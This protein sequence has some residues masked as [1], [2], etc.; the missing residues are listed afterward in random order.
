MSLR[1]SIPRPL[2]EHFQSAEAWTLRVELPVWF[3]VLHCNR[4]IPG[5]KGSLL[6]E[7]MGR[8]DL[9]HVELNAKSRSLRDSQP[10]TIDF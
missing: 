9:V 7:T 5:T 1:S 3:Q 2:P 6:V 8:L 4:V 10:S